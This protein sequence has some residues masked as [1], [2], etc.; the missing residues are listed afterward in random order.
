MKG[1]L[2]MTAQYRRRNPKRIQAI[3]WF[4]GFKDGQRVHPPALRRFA[5]WSES[6]QNLSAYNDVLDL[7]AVL[8][9]SERPGDSS[10][11]ELHAD[12]PESLSAF[13]GDFSPE[14]TILQGGKQN[15][16]LPGR[17]SGFRPRLISSTP[18]GGFSAPR[19]RLHAQRERSWRWPAGGWWGAACAVIV[20]AAAYCAGQRVML[21][22]EVYLT[23]PGQ[24]RVVSLADGSRVTLGGASE[25]RVR[26]TKER[27]T[28]DL[29]RGEALFTVTHDPQRPFV[30][31]AGAGTITAV[32]TEFLVRRYSQYSNRIEV[33]VTRGVVQVAPLR[34]IA[35]SLSSLVTPVSWRATRL[36]SGEQMAYTARGS[37]TA[38]KRSDPHPATELTNGTFIYH[39]RPLGEV[40]EDV[41]RY[42]PQTIT[43]DSRS[44]KLMYSGSVLERDVRQWL[45]GLPQ[46]FPGV[47]VTQ[48]SDGISIRYDPG[49]SGG[50]P[51]SANA[52]NSD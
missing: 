38:I 4:L 1:R 22:G 45:R 20:L 16:E 51:S 42:T 13:E 15:E 33:W 28:I 23:G 43:L 31:H 6:P 18:A 5:S 2:P 50:D 17:Q 40:I 52:A 8:L 30:V 21:G 49:A 29:D 11:A 36:A 37:A 9:Q 39:G 35:L 7:H 25:I 14:L 10:S 19:E 3:L 24:Q 26:L 27:R 44:A 32:G 46:I 41:Q 12:T 48:R 47:E 34:G